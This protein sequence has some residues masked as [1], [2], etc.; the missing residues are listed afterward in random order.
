[1]TLAPVAPPAAGP[2]ALRPLSEIEYRL[3]RDLV[4]RETG[5]HLG[6]H[7]KALIV[8][9]LGR[10]LRDLGLAR[11]GQ[12]HEI[13]AADPAERTRMIE[14]LCTHE[15]SFFREPRQ[16]ELLAGRVLPRW[17]EEAEAGARPRRVR[18]WS[19][20][21]ATGEEPFSIAMALLHALPGWS[22]DVL[23]TDLSSQALAAARSATW[24]IR[25]AREIPPHLLKRFMR[26]GTRSQEGWMRAGPELREVIRFEPLNLHEPAWAL[27]ARFDLVFCRNVL[28]YFDAASKARAIH[29]LIDHL[30][31]EGLLFL[32]HSESLIGLT[33][34]VRAVIPTVYT[35]TAGSVR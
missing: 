30:A 22:V 16:F 5:I 27:D 25:R 6:P 31:P 26:K 2:P 28:I 34:R 1:M 11:F 19:A 23:A 13:V 7:K 10:R 29:R 14:R 15:T 12:Y 18:A 8:S 35:L 21:C 33:D 20:G 9:R 32:G 24:P 4:Y 3:L 17:A